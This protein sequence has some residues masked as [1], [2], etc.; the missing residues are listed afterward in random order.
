MIKWLNER[1][2]IKDIIDKQ[3]KYP[4][5]AHANM[6]FCF[7]GLAFFLIVLQVLTGI[8]MMFFYVPIAEKAQDS[9]KFICNEI[10]Y[11]GLIRNIHRWGATLIF[12]FLFIH[13]IN[14]ITRR[15]YKSPRELNWLSGIILY[16]IMFIFMI[17]GI[18]LPWDWR[19]YWELVVWADWIGTI[20]IIGKYLV[21]PLI[22]A[23]SVGKSFVIHVWILPLITALLL[24]FHFKLVR[25][26]GVAEPL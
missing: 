19:S 7:G 25:K 26:L 4:I 3:L 1:T 21:E 13:T 9:V 8:F 11:G 6:W 5:P 15:A 22:L 10:P 24:R 18:V 17:T 2:G 20:P 23:F 12:A 16:M 14:V